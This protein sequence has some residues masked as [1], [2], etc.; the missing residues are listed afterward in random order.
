[1]SRLSDKYP[2]ALHLP[3]TDDLEQLLTALAPYLHWKLIEIDTHSLDILIGD[4]NPMGNEQLPG[5]LMLL[6]GKAVNLWLHHQG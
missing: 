4:L 3:A 1:M 5:R 6:T 2:S